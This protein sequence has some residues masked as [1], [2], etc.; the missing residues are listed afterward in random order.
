MWKIS[1]FVIKSFLIVDV[2]LNQKISIRLVQNFNKDKDI[3]QLIL[4]NDI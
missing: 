1:E 4:T 2:Y 3:Y